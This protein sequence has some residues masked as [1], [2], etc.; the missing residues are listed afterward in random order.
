[1]TDDLDR[2][3]VD[4]VI[5]GDVEAFAGIVIRWQRPLVNLAWRF[6]HDRDRAEEMAQEAFVRAFR[7]LRRWRGDGAFS[8][9]LIALALNSY[10]D[11]MRRLPAQ[12]DD[13]ALERATA[14][15]GDLAAEV[16]MRDR[17]RLVRRAVRALPPRYREAVVLFYFHDMDTARAA[18]TLSVPEGTFKTRLHR[19]RDLLR[20]RLIGLGVGHPATEAI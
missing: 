5:G 12:L 15:P 14:A 9:W 3:D 18:R 11:V 4:R 8:S 6:C 19:G 13:D 1:M 2:A 17:A 10:R 7:A 20:R 16:E